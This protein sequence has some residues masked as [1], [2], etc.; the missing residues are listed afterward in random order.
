[1]GA[2]AGELDDDRAQAAPVAVAAKV[3]QFPTDAII[4][5][6]A[7]SGRGRC[8]EWR[9]VPA[10]GD[11]RLVDAGVLQQIWQDFAPYREL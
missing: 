5:Q 2:A 9:A 11:T 1:M 10:K 7:N 3:D 4:V 8:G 6:A